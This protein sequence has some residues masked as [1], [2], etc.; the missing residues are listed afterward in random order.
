M[1]D[2][3]E[4]AQKNY[5]EARKRREGLLEQVQKQAQQRKEEQFKEQLDHFHKEI[6]DLIPDFGEEVAVKIRDFAVERGIDATMLDG[7]VDPKV[8]KFIDDFRRLDQGVSKG[9][10]KRKGTQQKRA[11]PTKKATPAQKKKEAA[12]DR[13]RKKALSGEGSKDDQDAFL[14]Q[15]ATRSLSN[16]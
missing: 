16:L 13:I 14:K 3:R 10:A 11:V 12:A 4:Q 8:I 9:V 6:P 2:Q 15:L 1:K 7:I 5:W